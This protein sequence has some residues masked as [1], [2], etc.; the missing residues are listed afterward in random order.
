MPTGAILYV[1]FPD[2][3]TSGDWERWREAFLAKFDLGFGDFGE[4]YVTFARAKLLM[5]D[6]DFAPQLPFF[7]GHKK[8]IS[9]WEAFPKSIF[10]EVDLPLNAHYGPGYERGN[11]TAFVA[12]GEWFEENIPD[13][14]V[15]Y[16]ND[17]SD[18]A[19]IYD[20]PVRRILLDYYQKVGHE[21]YD[22][23]YEEKYRW[24]G[25]REECGRLWGLEQERVLG[26]VRQ[27]DGI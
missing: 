3:T 17:C 23:K 1:Q 16:A 12:Y 14:R 20:A 13:S 11:L 25:V 9:L 27:H 22:A 8:G 5:P 26:E 4:E 7:G 19:L 10:L 21:P 24:D 18:T 2:S 15:W 6:W